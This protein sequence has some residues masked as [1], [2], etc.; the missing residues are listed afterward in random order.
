MQAKT[1]SLLPIALAVA[2]GSRLVTDAIEADVRYWPVYVLQSVS[3]D[4]C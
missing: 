1:F 2:A 3:A 4:D